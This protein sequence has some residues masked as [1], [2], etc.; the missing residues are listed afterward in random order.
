MPCEASSTPVTTSRS[1]TS[2]PSATP[3]RPRSGW[4]SA[5][6]AS[7]TATCR[8]STAPS[9]GRHRRC[10]ATRGPAWSRRSVREVRSVKPG[11]HVVIATLA[12]C[13]TC[14]ACSTGHPTWCVKTLGQR[15][16]ALHLQGRAGVQLRRHLGVHRVDHRQGG[17]GRQDLEGRAHDLGLPDRLRR[18][19]RRG[20]GAQPG[21]GPG[22]RD[23]GR[24]RGRRRRAST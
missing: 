9:R 13:G 5:P 19:D 20:R 22:R 6:P 14:R 1:P 17:P 23:L 11:D 4:P 3:G 16:P 24:L 2:W 8:S 10:S 12:S 7:A 15:V 18:A 21:Q